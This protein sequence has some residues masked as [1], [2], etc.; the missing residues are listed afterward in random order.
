M[1]TKNTKGDTKIQMGIQKQKKID[2]N[3][4]ESTNIQKGIQK[5]KR[6]NKNKSEYKERVQK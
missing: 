1:N 5:Y 6:K 3:T 2:K 4:I